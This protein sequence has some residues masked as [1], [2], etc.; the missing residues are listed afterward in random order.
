MARALD[1]D[2]LDGLILGGILLSAGGSGQARSARY[3]TLGEQALATAPLSLVA[4]DELAD[5]APIIIGTASA[6]PASRLR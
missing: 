1:R 6:R 2:A 4:L 3:R 5:D